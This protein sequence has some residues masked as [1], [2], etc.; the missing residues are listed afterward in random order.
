MLQNEENIPLWSSQIFVYICI[1][2]G[3]NNHFRLKNGY[4]SRA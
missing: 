2:R 1:T 4:F 3:E